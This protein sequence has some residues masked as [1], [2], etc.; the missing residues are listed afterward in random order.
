MIYVATV[1]V[2]QDIPYLILWPMNNG[3]WLG[4]KVVCLP[5]AISKH[6]YQN[7]QNNNCAWT[8]SVAVRSKA[9]VCR[10]S[11]V[12][13]GGSNPAEGMGTPLLFVVCC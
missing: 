10:R 3:E 11:I 4:M 8:N 12:E 5:V 7:L 1:S 2:L 13:T 9:Y 6:K